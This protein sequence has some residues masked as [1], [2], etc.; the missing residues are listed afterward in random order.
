MII[1]EIGIPEVA[2]FSLNT[3]IAIKIKFQNRPYGCK[4]TI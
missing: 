3:N 1:L 4:L 2:A